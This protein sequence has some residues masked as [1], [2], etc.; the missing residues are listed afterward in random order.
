VDFSLPL[1]C[2]LRE[3]QLPGSRIFLPSL[4]KKE[5]G[6]KNICCLLVEIVSV[7]KVDQRGFLPEAESRI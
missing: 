4:D 1:D 3:L 6:E 5:R 2:K 7:L